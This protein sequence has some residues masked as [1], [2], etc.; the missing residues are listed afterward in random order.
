MARIG[1]STTT[2]NSPS[3]RRVV[4]VSFLVDLFDVLTNLIVAIL[5]GSA[6]VFAEMAQGIADSVGSGFLVIGDRRSTRPRDATHPRGYHRE[7]FFWAFLSALSMLLIGA[8]LS[9]W[10]GYRQLVDPGTIEN[11][12][13]AFGVLALAIATNGYAVRLSVRNL[14][15]DE[16]NLRDALADANRPLV[17]SALFRDLIGTTTSVVGLLALILYRVFD[18][19]FFDSVGALL[20]AVLMIAA[21]FMLMSQARDLIAGRSLP[22][23]DL[24]LLRVAVA[25]TPGV[26]AIN[27]IEAVHAGASGVDVHVDIDLAEGLNTSEIE[28]VLDDVEVRSRNAMPEITSLHVALNSP[29][30]GS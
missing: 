13:L 11:S 30:S 12:P 24:E 14:V 28:T 7:V 6:V 2:T 26:E 10:R 22:P 25:T 16:G 9:A 1:R 19:V 15:A 3:R 8:S 18:M 17:K 29:T 20:A 4:V 27:R 21:S 23:D 5:T